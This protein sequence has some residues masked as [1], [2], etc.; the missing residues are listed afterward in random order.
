MKDKGS[1]QHLVTA[2]T[3]SYADTTQEIQSTNIWSER[4]KHPLSPK[5]SSTVIITATH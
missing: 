3:S 2:V 5:M 1:P 4:T